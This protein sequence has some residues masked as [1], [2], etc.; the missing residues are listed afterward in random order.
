MSQS[1][2]RRLAL[3]AAFSISFA[4]LAGLSHANEPRRYVLTTAGTGG[5]Y[6]PVGVAL[7][8]LAK[9][10]LQNAHGIDM[11]AISSA[12]SGENTV[13]L[14]EKQ[15][16]FAIM[17]G[18]FGQ[19]AREGTGAL[20]ESGPQ[21]NMRS[22]AMLWPN[23]EHF[24]LH[25]SLTK[26]GTASDMANL[27]GKGYSIGARNS[28][29]EHSNKFLFDNFGFDYESWNLVYQ[30]FGPSIDTLINGGIMGVNINSGIGVGTVTRA[31]AQMGD[32]ISLLSVT[33]EELA[34]F[35]GGTG[36]YF[37]ITIPGGTYPGL[38][39]DIVTIA[40]PN[41]LAVNADVPE[42]DVYLF[43]K[44]IYENLGFVC[45]IHPATCD[46]SLD[47]A[48]AG[49]PLPLHAGAARFYKE[50]GLSIPD[51]IAPAE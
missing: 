16:Q 15:A 6:Y 9:I 4:G 33:D 37:H 41:F 24:L 40:Q 30:G 13:L 43:T 34:A 49:L 35:D 39:D 25:S 17:Q 48:M 47:N 26:T 45:N 23:V 42:E 12:G 51:N 1:V 21:K 8:T 5:T 46:M 14:R 7:A 50:A 27:T 3:A 32:N 31:R 22:I 36:L 38:D 11:S 29:T 28:G 20:K 2:T 44:T 19:W 18:L 10:N